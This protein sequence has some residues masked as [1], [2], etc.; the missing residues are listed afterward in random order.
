MLITHAETG[1]VNA[2][3]CGLNVFVRFVVQQ[4]LKKSFCLKLCS[5]TLSNL[6]IFTGKVH[7]K[8]IDTLVISELR[9]FNF[10]I[11]NFQQNSSLIQF[12]INL[13]EKKFFKRQNRL[14]EF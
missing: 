2:P 9:I 13:Q 12:N 11:L 1:C 3:L 4:Q 14:S 10:L 6:K 7:L 8:Q 5:D